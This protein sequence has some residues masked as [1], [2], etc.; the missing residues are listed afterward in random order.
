MKTKRECIKT[1]NPS[2]VLGLALLV[3]ALAEGAALA[4]TA[5]PVTRR[6][7]P[8][9]KGATLLTK[10]PPAEVLPTELGC[11][12]LAR[13]HTNWTRLLR[14]AEVFRCP[15]VRSNHTVHVAIHRM[16]QNPGRP[17][18]I[19]IHGVLS[20]HGMWEYVTPE[21]GE[22]YEVWLVDLPGCGESDVPKP[23]SIEPDGYSPT[24][25]AER[26][27]QALQ[28]RLT[29]EPPGSRR[30]LIVVGHSLGGTVCIRLLSAPE[31]RSRYAPVVDRVEGM[32][33]F[34]PGD[35][36][37]NSVPPKFLKLLGLE[38]WMVDAACGL[39]AWNATVRDLIKS[40]YH[41]PECATV[42]RQ[43]CM[44]HVLDDAGHLAAAK[45]MLRQ[46]TPFDPKTKR[47][48]W[49]EIDQLVAD[50]RNIRVP[51][52]V[53]HGIWDETLPIATA[54]KLKNQ[55]PGAWLVEVAHGGHSL[56]TEHPARCTDL[57]RQFV[58]TGV[59]RVP[60]GSQLRVY[61]GSVPATATLAKRFPVGNPPESG[62]VDPRVEGRLP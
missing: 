4:G 18:L 57:I 50:Y 36:A 26:L 31:L 13:S 3:L 54:H 25:M 5:N 32:V 16:N 53:V 11:P 1:S 61:P 47:P 38:G 14:E 19:L 17:V 56:P 9:V 23:S 48:I 37:I 29:A 41:R 62:N 58:A 45:A 12:E 7:D 34:A 46:F 33:L 15:T 39:G 6:P 2:V 8:F 24:G 49:P 27:L 55:V 10:R 20:D 30:P 43:I 35:L 22:D 28:Q 21:L 60:I 59:V 42:E 52:L 44:A 40:G 51:V